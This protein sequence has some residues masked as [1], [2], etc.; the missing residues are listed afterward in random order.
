MSD[1]A[2]ILEDH[3]AA[4]GS[5]VSSRAISADPFYSL[6]GDTHDAI[7]RIGQGLVVVG[8]PLVDAALQKKFVDAHVVDRPSNDPSST[9]EASSSADVSGLPRLEIPVCSPQ[10]VA[11]IATSFQ[12]H[13]TNNCIWTM[14]L[15][16]S[17]NNANSRGLPTSSAAAVVLIQQRLQRLQKDYFEK[18][19]ELFALAST[20]AFQEVKRHLTNTNIVVLPPQRDEGE[21]SAATT[22]AAFSSW[23]DCSTSDAGRALAEAYMLTVLASIFLN[24][25]TNL[26]VELTLKNLAKSVNEVASIAAKQEADVLAMGSS[27]ADNAAA[28]FVAFREDFEALRRRAVLMANQLSEFKKALRVPHTTNDVD[29]ELL[30]HKHERIQRCLTL[31]EQLGGKSFWSER[32]RALK[33]VKS[34]TLATMV[35]PLSTSFLTTTTTA[36]N[37]PVTTTT[38]TARVLDE[39]HINFVRPIGST[40]PFGVDVR[41][42]PVNSSSEDVKLFLTGIEHQPNILL[43]LDKDNRSGLQIVAVNGYHE[44]LKG[45]VLKAA[46]DAATN[47][48]LIRVSGGTV[49]WTAVTPPPATSIPAARKEEEEVTTQQPLPRSLAEPKVKKAVQPSIQRIEKTA[50]SN[51]TRT[52]TAVVA[53]LSSSSVAAVDD[54]LLT[55]IGRSTP[56][57][58]KGR[59]PVSQQLSP[60][61]ISLDKAKSIKQRAKEHKK[62]GG[63]NVLASI[64]GAAQPQ[65]DDSNIDKA[66][67]VS[68]ASI[69][70]VKLVLRRSDVS[71][72][73]GLFSAQP[74]ST[75]DEEGS[76]AFDS[77][78]REDGKGHQTRTTSEEGV[79]KL[80]V[81]VAAAVDDL[82]TPIGRS[83]P[84]QFKGRVP[85]SQQ[86]SPTTISLDKGKSIKQRAKEHKKSGGVNV[87]ASISG[88]AQPQLDDSN[89]DKADTVSVASITPVKLVLRRSD[90]T[91][92]W[93]IFS[94]Q[95]L[96][97]DDDKSVRRAVIKHIRGVT[98]SPEVPVIISETPL[99][100]TLMT[101]QV[102]ISET[103]LELTLM[104]TNSEIPWPA[105]LIRKLGVAPPP[106]KITASSNVAVAKEVS[107]TVVIEEAPSHYDSSHIVVGA[108]KARAL[109]LRRSDV[110]KPWG[111][112]TEGGKPITEGLPNIVTHICGIKLDFPIKAILVPEDSGR[113]L[114]IQVVPPRGAPVRW[115]D[116]PHE[117]LTT[118]ASPPATAPLPG[119]TYSS[120]YSL[121]RAIKRHKKA[122]MLLQC[123]KFAV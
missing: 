117:I 119:M 24:P 53:K 89:I 37:N 19:S 97:T 85:V 65:L 66:D 18:T 61:T 88:T 50:K 31:W 13:T 57:Q 14:S 69:T 59:V 78:D 27:S 60:T 17:S 40:I 45:E 95:P 11:N 51:S 44:P 116:L 105:S 91:S 72:R 102:I 3:D 47:Q 114:T 80:P 70:P 16:S 81:S 12:N 77:T 30:T 58:F 110:T 83:A 4:A 108:Q 67:T 99:E 10:V 64:S 87:L 118:A 35:T 9:E 34:T 112:K 8:S 73:W 100:L 1:A 56:P 29:N 93:G 15:I 63:V 101:I 43:E 98:L 32:K 74:V 92:R 42:E 49:R 39:T 28:D 90:V 52:T 82:L 106:S 23:E 79:A 36:T 38:V 41:L 48:L 25:T 121:E 71:S 2:S 62:N 21:K 122:T 113:A 120:K 94:A 46:L 54:T 5:K 76:A 7:V 68:V 115:P 55:P 123:V 111:I 75:D 26:R 20:L 22:A 84:P 104:T 107:K 86:F 96:S 6:L 103:P 109:Q 33:I